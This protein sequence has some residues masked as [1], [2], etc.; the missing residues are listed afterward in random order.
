MLKV[1]LPRM[2]II[3]VISTFGFGG[4]DAPRQTLSRSPECQS[5]NVSSMRRRKGENLSTNH[6]PVKLL[7]MWFTIKSN[8]YPRDERTKDLEYN[9]NVVQANPY[10]GD[11]DRMTKKGM[12]CR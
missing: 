2:L 4:G 12:V 8:V 6:G 5:N 1:P 7:Q 11:L 9:S 3:A 10:I